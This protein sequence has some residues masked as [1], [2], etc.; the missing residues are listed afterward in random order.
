MTLAGSS[1]TPWLT[2]HGRESTSTSGFDL[3]KDNKHEFKFAAALATKM[4]WFLERA[5][6]MPP[7]MP[8]KT[9][10]ANTD[11]K[12]EKPMASTQGMKRILEHYKVSYWTLYALNWITVK[13]VARARPGREASDAPI[14]RDE[15]C[16]L[17][18]DLD[19]QWRTGKNLIGSE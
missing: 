3:H 7:K 14:L 12:G 11:K 18:S 2:K 17:R 15:D 16:E 4:V 5:V 10:S 13:P 9:F 6:F 1:S 8:P 19:A